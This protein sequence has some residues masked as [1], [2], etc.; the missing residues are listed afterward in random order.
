MNLFGVSINHRTASIESR[1]K[2]HFSS[3]EILSYIPKLKED[4]FSEGI[5]LSTCN[6]TEI[7]GYPQNPL[8]NYHQLIEHL[9]KY[10]PIDG[11]EESNFEKYFSCSAVNHLFS[12]SAGIDSLIL[13]DSQILSQVKDAIDL[14]KDLDFTGFI[15]QKLLDTAVRVG[16]RSIRESLIGEGAV[17]ISYAAV[18][19]VEK[20]FANL[21]TKSALVIGAGETGELAA[22]H[23][24]DKGI[25]EIAISNRTLEKAERLSEKVDGEIILFP[26]IA[27][28]LHKFDV[29]ISATSAPDYIIALDDIKKMM[30]TRRGNPI[31]LMDIALPRD[32]DPN[33]GKIDNVFYNDI[34]SLQ[35]IVDQNFKRRKD[36]VPKVKRIIMEEMIGFFGWFNSLEVIPTI[37]DLREF[38][39]EIRN[40][41]LEKIK[42]KVT[43]EDYRK[44]EDMTR[45]MMGR[46][47]HNPTVN[48]K[49]MAESGT[50]DKETAE[51]AAVLKKLF[52][53]NGYETPEK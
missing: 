44:L 5:V 17:S 32:I 49:R 27:S 40:D 37:K 4:L 39:D 23:L 43:E 38:F 29:I 33:V 7:F 3:D 50:N 21:A 12:V 26:N 10:K 15:T 53:L 25:G 34:D 19:V 30:K 9:L 52:N 51:T 16:K 11:I 24:K 47:L 8:L 42:H 35:S 2:L 13:G 36:E 31:V 48:L 28:H 20:I 41:E 6:R 46:I 45:R 18:Q 1:E 22:L 14:S